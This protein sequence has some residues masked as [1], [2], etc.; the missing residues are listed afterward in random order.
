M[1]GVD[2]AAAGA[3]GDSAFSVSGHIWRASLVAAFLVFGVGGWAAIA[4]LQ[5]AVIAPGTFVVERN[6]K[7]VQH[8]Y[9]GIVSQINVKNGDRVESGQVVIKLDSTQIGAEM[10][11]IKSQLVELIARGARLAAERDNLPNIV[12]PNAFIQTYSNAQETANGEIRLFEENRSAKEGQKQQLRLKIEQIKEEITGLSAQRDAKS[13]ELQIIEK[14]LKD[15]RAMFAKQL[16]TA[17]R[18]NSL[19]REAT[20]LAGDHGGLV[21]QIARAKGQINEINVQ[22]LSVDENMRANAQKELRAI[23]AKVSE[24]LERQVAAT[25]KLNRIEIRAPRSGLVH[26][27]S[28][29]TVGGVVSPAEVLMLVVPEEEGLQIQARIQPVNVDQ[30]VIGRPA[31]LRLSAFAQKKTPEVD[32]RVV[33]VAADVTLDPKTG[34]SYYAVMVEMDEKARRVTGDL[35]LVAGM[36]VEVFMSTGERTALSYLTK[37]FTDQMSRAFRE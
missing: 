32:G 34:Q 18:L 23:D 2:Q 22:I 26:E 7:K 8:S 16:T 37:P 36:P 27:L 20:R 3:L 9:G 15:V 4:E 6:V 5:G 28:V 17:T 19:E 14:E 30:V 21:A 33:H 1:T 25:D 29:H 10:G 31:R 35:K 24:L 12:W 13:S 11:V